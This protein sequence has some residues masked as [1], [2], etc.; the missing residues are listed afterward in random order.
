MISLYALEAIDISWENISTVTGLAWLAGWLPS[1]SDDRSFIYGRGLGPACVSHNDRHRHACIPLQERSGGISKSDFEKIRLR[2]SSTAP[3]VIRNE[4][5]RNRRDEYLVS[6]SRV[7]ESADWLELVRFRS[8]QTLLSNS[9][10]SLTYFSKV[11]C[12]IHSSYGCSK[13][14]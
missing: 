8:D 6:R 1:I 5:A 11:R 14:D 4:I 2:Q 7:W 13:T 10:C 12:A 9:C 3:G